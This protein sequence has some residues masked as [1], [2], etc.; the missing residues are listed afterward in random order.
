MKKA[1][2]ALK[3]AVCAFALTGSMVLFTSCGGGGGGGGGSGNKPATLTGHWVR[4]YE[5]CSAWGVCK[6]EIENMELFKDG[7]GAYDGIGV[8]WKIENNR[9][10][11]LSPLIAM[12][13]DYKISGYEL[14]LVDN[15]GDTTTYV[16]K[17]KLEEYKAKQAAKKEKQ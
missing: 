1:V 16:R 6:D 13:Y 3:A 4:E 7:T 11:I 17:E 8:T 2:T 15:E 12:S 14:A 9:L 5:K 10:V